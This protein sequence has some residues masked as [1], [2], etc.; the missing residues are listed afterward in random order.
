MRSI[1]CQAELQKG[2]NWNICESGALEKRI[3]IL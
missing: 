3:A 1:F 2:A